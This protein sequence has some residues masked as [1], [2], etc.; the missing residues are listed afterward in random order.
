MT[1]LKNIKDLLWEKYADIDL[2]SEDK[3]TIVVFQGFQKKHL[4]GLKGNFFSLHNQ[5]TTLQELKAKCNSEYIFKEILRNRDLDEKKFWMTSEEFIV[6][7]KS[8]ILDLFNVCVLKNN[9]YNKLFPYDDTLMDIKNV[10]KQYY[11]NLDSEIAKSEE[12]EYSLISEFYGDVIYSKTSKNYYVAYNDSKFEG[13]ETINLFNDYEIIKKFQE[14]YKKRPGDTFVE[15]SEDETIILDLT[16]EI[17]NGDLKNKTIAIV[18]MSNIDELPNNYLNRLSILGSLYKDHLQLI[19]VPKK[20]KAIEIKNLKEYQKILEEDL[21]LTDFRELDM[22]EDVKSASKEIIKVSQVQIINDIVEQAEIALNDDNDRDYRDIFITSST[23]SGK[24]MMFQLSTMYLKKKHPDLNPLTIVVSPLI[25]LMKDQVDSLKEVNINIAR[26]INSN[27]DGHERQDIFNEIQSGECFLLYVS[28]ETLQ[29]RS[30]IKQLIGDRRLGLVIVDEAHI[31]TTWGKTFRADYWYLGIF[32]QK[33]RKK[34]NFPI[35]TFTATAIFGG[36]EDM[37]LEIRNSLNMINPISYFG[38]VRRDDIL[39]DIE[40][41]DKEYKKEDK[42]YKKTKNILVLKHIEKAYKRGEKSLI[43][44]P[45]IKELQDC[46]GQIQMNNKILSELTGRYHGKMDK[47]EKN[48]VMEDFKEGKLRF[49]LATKAFG[50]GVD[51]DDINNVYHYAPTGTVTDYIQEI[52]RAARNHKKVPLGMACFDY[53]QRDFTSIKQLNAMSSISSYELLGIMEKIINLYRDKGSHRNLLVNTEDFKYVFRENRGIDS[54][55]DGYLDNRVK[56]ALL[57]IEKDFSSPKKLG[58][59]P[60]VARPRSMYGKD[61]IILTEESLKELKNSKLAPY[62]SYQYKVKNS[63]YRWVYSLNLADL[64]EDRYRNLS[65]PN[66]K[67]IL[68]T[69]DGIEEFSDSAVL[70]D[71]KYVSILNINKYN[72]EIKNDNLL[73]FNQCI[74]A[75]ASFLAIKMRQGS[76]FNVKEVGRFLSNKLKIKEMGKETLLARTLIN[77]C[78]DYQEYKNYTFIKAK[79]ISNEVRYNLVSSY[80]VFID[81]CKKHYLDFFEGGRF[82]IESQEGLK[83]AY[84]KMKSNTELE[85]DL[86]I[87]SIAEALRI[88]TYNLENGSSNE[89][90]VRINSIDQMERAIKKGNKYWNNILGDLWKQQ[91]FNMEFLNYLFKYKV[92]AKNKNEKI[93]KYTNFFWDTIEEYFIGGKVPEGL[94]TDH[95]K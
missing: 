94:N 24:S 33:L 7:S 3:K 14:D 2:Q 74:D 76:Y 32:L 15:L 64:W 17:T 34:Y 86:I 37:Y 12:E 35:V 59:S 62:I 88:L 63:K 47:D 9:L 19:L 95:I 11:Y 18:T 52:G 50:M 80:D 60:F 20:L 79:N 42:D 36:Q 61:N 10:Y 57:M 27:T 23:G 22:Y 39:M 68:Y 81:F 46:Y 28:P 82:E 21:K 56:I 67:R 69:R 29:S 41:S 78:L 38:K 73:T 8:M 30:D 54:S 13:L 85:R 49:V 58:Y 45:T 25:A 55:E 75:F 72:Q 5:N 16:G 53:L 92:E 84:I 31:V 44:F 93:R 83:R 51:V 77:A 90:Y 66:F 89:I 40:A 70:K 6:S 26:T 43:Y 48:S 91:K 4:E 87:V 1:G 65:F 71:L